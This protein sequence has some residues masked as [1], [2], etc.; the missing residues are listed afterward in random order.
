[1]FACSL[2]VGSV[3]FLPPIRKR[4]E[5]GGQIGQQG[6]SRVILCGKVRD[7]VSNSQGTILWMECPG[8]LLSAA[9][10][11]VLLSFMAYIIT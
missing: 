4:P 5:S 11:A 8:H 9:K 6:L 1:M 2:S 10:T 7:Q 3:A